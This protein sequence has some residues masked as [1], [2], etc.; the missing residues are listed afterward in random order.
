MRDGAVDHIVDLDSS[1][2]I[3]FNFQIQ[4]IRDMVT[5]FNGVMPPNRMT[6]YI[7][8][9]I[10]KGRG[11]KII[12]S[13]Q[14]DI[15]PGMAL[16][17]PKRVIHST[18]RWSLDTAGY[19][20]TFSEALFGE[21]QFPVSYLQ[22]PQLFRL[23][24]KPYLVLN[25]E[26]AAYAERLFIELFQLR[27]ASHPV[28]RKLFILKLSELILLYHRAFVPAS[29]TINQKGILFDTFI[30][31]VEENFREHREVQYYADRL[32]IHANHLNRIVQTSCGY[33]AKEF[34]QQRV[35]MEAKYL[36]SA[37]KIPVKQIA[38]DLGFSD[39]NYFCRQFKQFV[40]ETPLGYRQSQC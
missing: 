16:I 36:L 26:I 37:T 40:K 25:T 20:L 28:D 14:F 24:R 29:D 18:N 27:E 22:L 23:S 5:E 33:S 38:Y 6:H 2:K 35:F 19:M 10:T 34:I 30:D 17:F 32:H 3:D 11:T 15:E 4:H 39:D 8:A 13:H 12:G 7:I 21:M 1:V 9:L 31:L